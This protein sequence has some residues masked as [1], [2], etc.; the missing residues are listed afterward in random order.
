MVSFSRISKQALDSWHVLHLCGSSDAVERLK[1]AYED[2][3]IPATVM[4]FLSAMGEAWGVADLAL[5][6]GGA[7][8][9]GELHANC[10]PSIIAPYPWHADNHQASNAQP[11]VAL[12]GVVLVE[13]RVEARA[14]LES[15]GVTLQRLLC[16]DR[17]RLSMRDAL[18]ASPPPDAA[19]AIAK[20]LLELS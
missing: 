16:D 9:I 12:G 13:D 14:N 5:S 8:S 1:R 19:E 10:V 6:R 17:A 7:S 2:A 18:H 15:I 4:P 20:R 3:A 11:L